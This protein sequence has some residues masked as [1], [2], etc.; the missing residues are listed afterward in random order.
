MEIVGALGRS[1]SLT[2]PSTALV[3]RRINPKARVPKSKR[4][5]CDFGAL[6]HT[7]QRSQ[8]EEIRDKIFGR[9][10]LVNAGQTFPAD[11][12]DE[13]CTI[14]GKVVQ[15]FTKRINDHFQVA[16]AVKRCFDLTFA[17]PA[18]RKRLNFLK[19]LRQGQS[20]DEGL[21]QFVCLVEVYELNVRFE[22]IM[23]SLQRSRY[24]VPPRENLQE[25]CICECSGCAITKFP[26]F[27]KTSR[28]SCR[29]PDPRTPLLCRSNAFQSSL[30]FF[31]HETHPWRTQD[32]ADSPQY[33]Y[34]C[35]AELINLNDR[36]DHCQRL[37]FH[38]IPGIEHTTATYYPSAEVRT[39]YA[40]VNAAVF[41]YPPT[42]TQDRMYHKTKRWSTIWRRT[43][44]SAQLRESL[45][46]V[47]QRR[48]RD[49][50]EVLD[51][52][53]RASGGWRKRANRLSERCG[54]SL[55][56]R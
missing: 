25:I 6:V 9:L 2:I 36:E 50:D 21:Q 3:W 15:H 35:S 41:G 42:S 13:L 27:R 45:A 4:M 19:R 23:T 8:C 34:V 48:R 51:S 16:D 5:D 55:A 44:T 30:F 47:E 33:T 18:R 56:G 26:P 40:V 17:P 1:H 10:G 28:A 43:D 11:Y 14:Y 24:A 53:V 37:L 39:G 22:A 49:V 12:S 32:S 7:F 29:P 20:M 52:L 54:R 38:Y 46:H 31:L